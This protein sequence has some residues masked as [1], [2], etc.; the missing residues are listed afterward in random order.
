MQKSTLGAL[1]VLGEMVDRDGL[2]R[3]NKRYELDHSDRIATGAFR[4]AVPLAQLP[5]ILEETLP[6]GGSVL[7]MDI[8]DE[9]GAASSVQLGLG[10][11][12]IADDDE[13]EVRVNGEPLVWDS[14]RM[15]NDGW[16]YQIFGS[17]GGYPSSIVMET[18]EGTLIE[19]GVPPSALMKGINDVT[20]R[21]IKGKSARLKPV[22]LKEVRL[23]ISYD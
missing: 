12:Q 1:R 15:S 16:S 11:H 8:A 14:H 13:L 6:H 21:L 23:L 3:L 4:Y 17:G 10:F 9:A 7:Q 19:L 18:V 22:V 5:V 20:V 2:P